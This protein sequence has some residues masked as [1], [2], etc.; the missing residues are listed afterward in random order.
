MDNVPFHKNM[1]VKNIIEAAG[2]NILLLPPYSPFLNPIE[3]KKWCKEAD[4]LMKKS[5]FKI[6][7]MHF[8]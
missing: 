8:Q 5:F 4:L 1:K 7:M 3:R 6:S 2:H